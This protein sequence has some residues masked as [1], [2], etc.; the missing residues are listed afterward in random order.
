MAKDYGNSLR[1]ASRVRIETLP[2]VFR[3]TIGRGDRFDFLIFSL[4]ATSRLEASMPGFTRLA[5]LT[6]LNSNGK[7]IRRFQSSGRQQNLDLVLEAGNYFI[8]VAATPRLRRIAKKY[9]L[10][11]IATPQEPSHGEI[12]PPPPENISWSISPPGSNQIPE[13]FFVPAAEVAASGSLPSQGSDTQVLLLSDILLDSAIFSQVIDSDGKDSGEDSSNLPFIEISLSGSRRL[14][15]VDIEKIGDNVDEVFQV[16]D[17]KITLFISSDGKG[18]SSSGK[19]RLPDAVFSN[20][21]NLKSTDITRAVLDGTAFAGSAASEWLYGSGANDTISGNDGD[22][23]LIGGDGDDV[24]DGGNGDNYLNGGSGNDRL[25]NSSAESSNIMRGGTGNDY[26]I[27][28]NSDNDIYEQPGGGTDIVEANVSFSLDN[29]DDSG[30]ER[31]VETLTLAE[32]GGAINGGGSDER[33]TL[34]GNSSDN[35]LDGVGG[36]D[37]IEG[38]GG[39]DLIIGSSGNDTLVGGEGFDVF[40]FND[41]ADGIDVIRDFQLGVDLIRIYYNLNFSSGFIGP[42]GFEQ[43]IYDET[44]GNL[45]FGVSLE[46]STIFAQ[47][48]TRPTFSQLSAVPFL[49]LSSEPATFDF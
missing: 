11:M 19:I 17:Y 33:N 23:Y 5:N 38:R 18:S 35:I 49:F 22:D 9:A 16:R 34:I 44:T 6:L 20:D 46:Q 2:K 13:G 3:N 39:N 32:A 27:V 4:A 24:L 41:P 1:V 14:F 40:A 26:Y 42:T 29:S 15:R 48:E 45:L 30:S 36:D 8:R 12:V 25:N 31:Y 37:V 10:R 28:R 43:I 21:N 47:L 7:P